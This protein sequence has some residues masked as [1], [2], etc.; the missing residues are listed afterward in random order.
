MGDVKEPMFKRDAGGPTIRN[1][2]ASPPSSCSTG[3]SAATGQ[4][5][6]TAAAQFL[7]SNGESDA[8]RIDGRVSF[9]LIRYAN[10]WEDADI[11]VEALEPL[12]GKRILSIASAGDN[13]LALLAEG[14]TVVAADLS[15]AQ[16]ACVELRCAAFR[17]LDYAGLLSFLGVLP[18]RDRLATYATKLEPDLSGPAR[19][20]WSG[21]RGTI[22]G[23]IIHGGKFESYFRLFR[24]RIIP[25]VHSRRDV[26]RLLE[27]REE[28]ER[29]TFY[30]RVWDNW[31]WR[32]LFRLF[33][34]RFVM[35]RLGRD[36]EF[37]RYVEGRV[38]DRLLARAKYAVTVLPTHENPFLEYILTG[39]FNRALPRYLRPQH[40]ESIRAGLDR[41][42]LFHGSI[43]EASHHGTP[44]DGF[45]L[46]DIFEYLDRSTSREIYDKLLGMAKTG[47]RFVYWNTLVPRHLPVELTGRVR[48]LTELS[49]RLFARDRAFFYCDFVVDEVGAASLAALV[50]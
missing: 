35:G 5:G 1:Q 31:R 22:E 18:H 47:A 28:T 40:F 39:N 3:F 36:P 7:G 24:R 4:E 38:S 45:N 17:R 8:G 44:F 30:D 10:C 26:I 12:A 6:G 2:G 42:T 48:P 43:D 16:L 20:F 14:A 41:V 19:Q 50:P 37:F 32:L 27:P 23:G 34:S 9:D 11:L 25:L 15:L 49:Q 33:F 13:V 29:H 46:S 21:K